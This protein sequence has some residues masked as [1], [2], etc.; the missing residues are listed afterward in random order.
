MN[1]I[2]V[3]TSW[4][5]ARFN[6]FIQSVHSI[7]GLKSITALLT[8]KQMDASFKEVI[9]QA[10]NEDNH[11]VGVLVKSNKGPLL[12]IFNY[13]QFTEAG[14]TYISTAQIQDG[15]VKVDLEGLK[16]IIGEYTIDLCICNG[17]SCL[18]MKMST[19]AVEQFDSFPHVDMTSSDE[20]WDPFQISKKN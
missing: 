11:H 12:C 18:K 15:N 3:C 7:N 5:E 13:V 19:P 17:N 8:P 20:S 16:L 6:Q 4:I 10:G 2:D 9:I 1:L 14:N